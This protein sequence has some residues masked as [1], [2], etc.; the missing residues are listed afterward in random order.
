M[1]PWITTEVAEV[2]AVQVG[3]QFKLVRLFSILRVF[4]LPVR[5]ADLDLRVILS[6]VACRTLTVEFILQL[7]QDLLHLPL[8]V[9][10]V[11]RR[12]EHDRR[13]VLHK[14]ERALDADHDGHRVEDDAP[15][16]GVHRE[17]HEAPDLPLEADLRVQDPEAL[18]PAAAHKVEAPPPHRLLESVL[19]QDHVDDLRGQLGEVLVHGRVG[20][21]RLGAGGLV[22]GR[23]HELLQVLR[24]G[25]V[26]RRPLAVVH[27]RLLAGVV[28]AIILPASDEPLHVGLEVRHHVA[29]EDAVPVQRVEGLS[30]LG[31]AAVHLED[32]RYDPICIVDLVNVLC[33][34]VFVELLNIQGHERHLHDP[35]WGDP[36]EL[37]GQVLVDVGGLELLGAVAVVLALIEWVNVFI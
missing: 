17:V 9:A 22:H 1:R 29:V 12:H 28:L 19:L 36:P 21:P 37:H 35:N 34:L 4:L 24:A 23:L 30:H 25:E 32:H 16:H 5:Q 14:V 8:G 10:V 27:Q 31:V 13:E 33:V 26:L 18:M 11:Q 2:L 15:R 7:H 20:P 3:Q 6:I